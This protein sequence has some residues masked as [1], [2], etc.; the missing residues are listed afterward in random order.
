MGS[1]PGWGRSHGEG[2]GNP[3][4]Y[5]C[6]ENPWTEEPGG[7]QSTGSQRVR[8]DWSDLAHTQNHLC[9]PTPGN[10]NP[11]QYSCLENPMDGEAREAATHG[12][13]KRRTRLSTFTSLHSTGRWL[14]P[15]SMLRPVVTKQCLTG[16]KKKKVR[17]PDFPCCQTR[18]KQICIC[19]QEFFLPILYN[20]LMTY[21]KLFPFHMNGSSD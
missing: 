6:L 14:L 13:A 3:V 18:K 5:C 2:H 16:R 17:F 15:L 10:G 21:Y 11:L 8:L 19:H 20:F 1:I 12:V 4:L 9:Q 7:L